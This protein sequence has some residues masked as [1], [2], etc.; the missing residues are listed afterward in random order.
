M[1]DG[2]VAPVQEHSLLAISYDI[3]CLLTGHFD[4]SDHKSSEQACAGV[5]RGLRRLGTASEENR[6]L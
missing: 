2:K 6:M 1:V 4:V 5:E 3:V